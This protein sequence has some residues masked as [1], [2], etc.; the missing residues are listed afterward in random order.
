MLTLLIVITVLF[1]TL[2]LYLEKMDFLSPAPLFCLVFFM[3]EI[4]CKTVS[5]VYDIHFCSET[6]VVLVLGFTAFTV[7][8]L[9]S[10]YILKFKISVS[11]GGAKNEIIEVSNAYT[12]ILIAIQIVSL[13]Y[14]Y[15]Y[16]QAMSMAYY[17]HVASLSKMIHLYNNMT[18]FWPDLYASYHLSIPLAYRIS[19]PISEA[20]G[21]LMIYVI[22]HNFLVNKKINVLQL[23]IPVLLCV[24]ILLNSSRSPLLRVVTM[25]IILIYIESVRQGKF[26]IGSKK[27]IRF[28]VILV[29]VAVGLVGIMLITLPLM[30]RKYNTTLSNYLFV[31]TGAPLLNLNQY[32]AKGKFP[33]A[34]IL[35]GYTFSN[36]IDYIN[37]I[38]KTSFYHTPYSAVASFTKSANGIDTGNVYT[39]FYAW[40]HDAGMHG[41]FLLAC[42]P[43]LFYCITYRI[44]CKI[45]NK[46][47][48]FNYLVFIYSYLFND[49]LMSFFS[50]RFYEN[51]F[52]AP[53]LKLLVISMLLSWIF[54]KP[55]KNRS[56]SR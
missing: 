9:F 5:K 45:P 53:F 11:K 4:I 46:K 18:N 43:A 14:F 33:E 31:Y 50:C 27:A 52:D 41:A 26:I 35:T 48:G 15:R 32:I 37:K 17:G 10:K 40:V 38:F 6:I 39:T 2:N 16:L 51:V 54:F 19:N 30:G 34:S 55:K 12:L 56:I 21:Y 13:Y 23:V 42:I 25:I 7:C 22:V 1:L 24:N 47:N 44:I 29:L 3:A 49:L 20:G 8:N 28:F 36:L